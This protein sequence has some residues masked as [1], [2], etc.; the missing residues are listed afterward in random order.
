MANPFPFSVGAVL[1]AAQMN[2]IGEITSFT[3]SWTSGLTPGNAVQNFKYV[4]IQNLIFVTGKIT[5]GT[6]TAITGNVSLATPVASSNQTDV[7]IV[8]ET[9]MQ[10]SGVGTVLGFVAYSGNSLFLQVQL[11]NGTYP[12]PQA[13]NATTPFTWSVNDT[14][15]IQATYTL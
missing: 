2:G 1:T 6:T 8:G 11:V 3:P 9:Y 15:S 13:F 14:I 7:S 5:F 10:D 4:R 12:A